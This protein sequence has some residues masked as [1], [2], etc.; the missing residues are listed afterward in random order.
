[1]AKPYSWINKK[2]QKKEKKTVERTDVKQK[3]S[4]FKPF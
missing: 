2:K 1:M 4:K 3:R